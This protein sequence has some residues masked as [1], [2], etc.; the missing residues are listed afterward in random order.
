MRDYN[1]LWLEDEPKEN[2]EF[3]EYLEYSFNI[4][5]HPCTV[6]DEG[7]RILEQRFDFWDAVLL[8]ARM[9]EHSAN[10]KAGEDGIYSFIRYVDTLSV[11]NNKHMPIFL[12]SGK[13][14]IVNDS[15]FTGQYKDLYY[16]K[17][18]DDEKL[19]Q[20]MIK[21]MDSAPRLE[22]EQ[23][24]QDYFRAAER[25]GISD[26]NNDI[27]TNILVPLHYQSANASFNPKLQYNQLRIFLEIL[28]RALANNDVI[29]AL[30]VNQNHG[31][32]NLNQ[33]SIYLSGKDCDVFKIRY[34]DQDDRII[35]V[36][37]ENIIRSILDLGNM[38]SHSSKPSEDDKILLDIIFNTVNSKYLVFAFTHQIMDV[39][40][41]FDKLIQDIKTGNAKLQ[42]C[43]K[44]EIKD[45]VKDRYLNKSFLPDRDTDGFWHCSE[46]FIT[47]LKYKRLIIIKDI[48]FNPNPKTKTKYPYFATFEITK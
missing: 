8:D 19:I 22:I 33:C 18:V 48:T 16:T 43:K 6:R 37:I 25:L 41:W 4:K 2:E 38:H 10:E 30:L 21:Q 27:I 36:Y 34:G 29:P 24:Y 46:C 31:Q 42:D 13:N 39:V 3:K 17:G 5:L 1:V 40:I 20:D 7:K 26:D 9:P 32:V 44:I 11:K 35:P 47:G 28:F 14:D 45:D 23:R 15:R 12:S